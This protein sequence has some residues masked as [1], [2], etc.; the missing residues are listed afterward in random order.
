MQAQNVFHYLTY[1]GF[2]DV[3]QIGDDMRRAATIEQ[4]RSFGQTPTQLFTA[5]H[6]PK[7]IVPRLG[8][9]FRSTLLHRF[10]AVKSEVVAHAIG[11]LFVSEGDSK[12]YVTR[13][14]FTI[15]PTAAAPTASTH[16]GVLRLL[17]QRRARL[18]PS[19]TKS[20]I[21]FVS[22]GF[23][24]RSVR[25]G[26]V[27]PNQGPS[28]F[29]KV[30]A[31]QW[32]KVY[33][34]MHDLEAVGVLA[35]PEVDCGLM[36]SAGTEDC[37]V[38]VW[39]AEL[40]STG[41]FGDYVH[42]GSLYGALSAR[43]LP[44][45][46][47]RLLAHR[48]RQQRFHRH[49]VG[50][51][52]P[53]VGPSAA[54]RP[55]RRRHHRPVL[56]PHQRLPGHRQPLPRRA[57]RRRR[58]RRPP[59]SVPP[60]CGEWKRRR[61]TAPLPRTIRSRP[62]V[63]AS[64]ATSSRVRVCPPAFRLHSLSNYHSSPAPA[65]SISPSEGHRGGRAQQSLSMRDPISC[66]H[67]VDAAGYQFLNSL[68]LIITGHKSG[69]VKLWYVTFDS[70]HSPSSSSPHTAGNT[71]GS[72]GLP[73]INGSASLPSSLPSDTVTL[74]SSAPDATVKAAAVKVEEEQKTV[75]GSG[76]TASPDPT[77]IRQLPPP[78]ALIVSSS[79]ID[80][81]TSPSASGAALSP[82]EG[83]KSHPGVRLVSPS[84][85]SPSQATKSSAAAPP[86][87]SGDLHI[88][89]E[90]DAGTPSL[91][92]PLSPAPPQPSPR[93][94]HLRPVAEWHRHQSPVTAVF[95]NSDCTAVWSGDSHG[96][97]IHWTLPLSEEAKVNT[98]GLM[99]I[100]VPAADAQCLCKAEK[101]KAAS[102]RT[103]V[104]RLC[105]CHPKTCRQ[106]VCD[107]CVLDHIRSRHSPAQHKLSVLAAKQRSQRE[108]QSKAVQ[109]VNGRAAPATAAAASE[110]APL[111]SSSSSSSF[112]S[113]S[114]SS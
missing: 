81:S 107:L 85:S 25:I 89:E 22:W 105:V 82:A 83:E 29:A 100:G 72:D 23:P 62:R 113:S 11:S 33:V 26:L 28:G 38:S 111:P 43:H 97:I 24:D 53:R 54:G 86:P 39:K 18:P 41:L 102:S 65:G 16:F 34:N 79:S 19:K 44:G 98:S 64:I 91:M 47:P 50:P 4:I 6:P 73:V 59:R 57:L 76:A 93:C 67:V 1:A 78:S 56:R 88:P 13:P 48:Q 36:V 55:L 63:L 27:G 95:V 92:S 80:T 8:T 58:Q 45:R 51:E 109:D 7:K 46:Q 84:A 5:P 40:L 31:V 14:G 15:V 101:G 17:S 32:N 75:E 52:P 94:W 69:K 114:S 106:V 96:S 21:G 108:S 68:L 37:V 3:D 42:H 2:V 90:F 104:R 10:K 77:I 87:Y 99:G 49:P 110:A 70:L 61:C 12:V 30:D 71:H 20:T 9:L 35:V 74:S 103:S 60:T 66:L 112:S